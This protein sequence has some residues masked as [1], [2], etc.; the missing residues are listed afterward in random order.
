MN[1]KAKF[2]FL[3]VLILIFSGCNNQ[4][5]NL[6]NESQSY[7]NITP[8]KENKYEEFSKKSIDSLLNN[9]VVISYPNDTYFVPTYLDNEHRLI[10]QTSTN[11][12]NVFLTIHNLSTLEFKKIKKADGT[13]GYTSIRVI[14]SDK[15][16]L[17]FEELDQKL[18]KSNLMIYRYKNGE[19]F[20]I[21]TICDIPPI[22]YSQ[23]TKMEDGLILNLYNSETKMYSNYI[24]TFSNNSLKIIEDEN[25]GFPI[26][27]N[28]KI[29]YV[30]IDNQNSITK[31]VEYN[32]KNGKKEILYETKGQE[33]YISGMYCDGNEIYMTLHSEMKEDWYFVDLETELLKYEFTTDLIESVQFKN[34]YL[35]WVGSPKIENRI[36]LEYFLCNSNHEVTYINDNGMILLSDNGLVC[37]TYKKQDVEIPKGEMYLDENTYISFFTFDENS[38][39]DKYVNKEVPKKENTY[40]NNINLDQSIQETEYYC[41]PAC[42]QMLFKLHDIYMSQKEIAIE[43][44]TVPITGTEYIDFARVIN[45]YVF[46]KEIVLDGEPGYRV[47][48]VLNGD[49]YQKFEQRVKIDVNSGD[50]LFV[51][52]DVSKLY[53]KLN[54][55]A[56]HMVIITGFSC[57]FEGNIINYYLVDPWYLVQD[58]IYK[59]LKVVSANELKNAMLAS[60]EPAY[61]W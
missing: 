16:Y 43:M 29:F 32:V 18:Q 34:G 23:A 15:D 5:N 22:S 12:E 51:S 59:G 54:V 45:K 57:D 60:N 41:A 44:N 49:Y 13:K 20:N 6:Q 28:K 11:D 38:S 30:L 56:N 3:L 21:T 40:D 55:S 27:Q 42:A 58:E 39:D 52:V 46:G 7:M 61:I 4:D 9:S 36:R 14:Y 1:G 48:N 37:I 24:Y 2:K 26:Y 47:Q 53:P 31:L 33:S 19:T 50:P 17:M 10:G 35:S 25:C 8:V